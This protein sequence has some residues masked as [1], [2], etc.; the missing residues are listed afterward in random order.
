MDG[1]AFY[2]LPVLGQSAYLF[3]DRPKTTLATARMAIPKTPPS[4]FE[5]WRSEGKDN[6]VCDT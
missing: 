3:G 4:K 2:I 1:W 6:L 5:G